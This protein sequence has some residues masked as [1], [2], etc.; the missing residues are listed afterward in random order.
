MPAIRHRVTTTIERS[1]MA[2]SL[3]MRL[4]RVIRPLYGGIGAI[5]MLHRVLPHGEQSRLAA[6]R[7]LEI[8]PEYL[9]RVIIQLQRHGYHAISMDRLASGFERQKWP[10]PFVC[11]SVDDG[12]ADTLTHALP[13]FERYQ[14]PFIVYVA[15][16]FIDGTIL[17]WHL[18]LEALLLASDRPT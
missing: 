18:V 10:T 7:R 8:T 17:P 3:R 4:D 6:N 2:L 14:I 15:T 9:E 13:V 1:V 5:L 12:Y 16:G 11:F